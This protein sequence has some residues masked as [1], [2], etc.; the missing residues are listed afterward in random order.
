MLKFLTKK[1]RDFLVCS[2]CAYFTNAEVINEKYPLLK[3]GRC[4]LYGKIVDNRWET[5]CEDNTYYCQC[6]MCEHFCKDT[7]DPNFD[8]DWKFNSPYI[9]DIDYMM[10]DEGDIVCEHFKQVKY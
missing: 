5:K 7:S 8:E 2:D 6:D 3:R 4:S 10:V 9:C 1:E